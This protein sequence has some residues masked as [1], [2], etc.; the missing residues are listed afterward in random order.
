MM[1]YA[2]NYMVL[3]M[4]GPGCQ[5]RLAMGTRHRLA[6]RESLP[7]VHMARALMQG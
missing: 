2:L 7:V 4:I 6:S 1:L 3:V 5:T